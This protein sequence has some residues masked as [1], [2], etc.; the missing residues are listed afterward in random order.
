M[1]KE[2]KIDI[3]IVME[4]EKKGVAKVKTEFFKKEI[5]FEEIEVSGHK[6]IIRLIPLWIEERYPEI[7]EAIRE[8]LN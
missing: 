4:N 8:A 7:D 1:N 6:W 3:E 2:R 5:E